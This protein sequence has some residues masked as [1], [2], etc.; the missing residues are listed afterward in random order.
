M[1]IGKYVWDIEMEDMSID[2]LVCM[3]EAC[4]DFISQKLRKT[5]E[6]EFT[7]LNLK[8]HALGFDLCYYNDTAPDPIPVPLDAF[9]FKA[10]PRDDSPEDFDE[11]ENDF[12]PYGT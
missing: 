12:Y 9:N 7:A 10:T 4:D 5:L 8:A 11:S 6:D 2:E 1:R 3:R